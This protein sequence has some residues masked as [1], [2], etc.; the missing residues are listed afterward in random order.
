VKETVII[1][2]GAALLRGCGVV[3]VVHGNIT[4]V[5]FERRNGMEVWV[6]STG[7]VLEKVGPDEVFAVSRR[8]ASCG[9][10]SGAELCR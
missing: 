7:L 10:A 8:T 3:D 5:E 1:D 9:L 4:I 6:R 2:K